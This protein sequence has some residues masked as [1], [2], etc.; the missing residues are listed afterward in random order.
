MKQ[1]WTI[2]VANIVQHC[3]TL[4]QA[5]QQFNI[6]VSFEQSGQQNIAWYYFIN[7]E[8][9]ILFSSATLT[10]FRCRLVLLWTRSG[11]N[12]GTIITKTVQQQKE[13]F[14]FTWDFMPTQYLST[15]TTLRSWKHLWRKKVELAASTNPACLRSQKTR[16]KWSKEHTTFSPIIPTR[17][18]WWNIGIIPTPVQTEQL[19]KKLKQIRYHFNPLF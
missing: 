8:Q 17:R 1:N 18:I 12:P 11:S 2:F 4:T 15:E 13:H 3:Y 19:L 9:S 6:V 14:N 16:K 10:F 7:L 5:K